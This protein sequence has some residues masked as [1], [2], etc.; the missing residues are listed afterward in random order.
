MVEMREIRE[1]KLMIEIFTSCNELYK[2]ACGLVVRASVC[3]VVDRPGF[4]LLPSQTKM[5]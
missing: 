5:L 4:D 1:S 2:T 3:L